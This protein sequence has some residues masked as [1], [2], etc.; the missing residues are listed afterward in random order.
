MH[1]CNIPTGNSSRIL[2][3][4][5]DSIAHSLLARLDTDLT[6]GSIGEVPADIVQ[7]SVGIAIQLINKHAQL[8]EVK[9]DSVDLD[10]GAHVGFINIVSFRPLKVL[11]T[12]FETV[13]SDS[14]VDYM[15]RW[16]VARSGKRR[17]VE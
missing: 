8:V 9:E 10:G 12:S 11:V 6:P 13:A 3:Y 7:S 17:A 2:I 1:R 14:P 5:R 15:V 16:T 4:L